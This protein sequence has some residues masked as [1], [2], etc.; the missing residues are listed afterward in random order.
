MRKTLLLPVLAIMFAGA[1]CNVK[2]ECPLGGG[3]RVVEIQIV[4]GGQT[5]T[6]SSTPDKGFPAERRIDELDLLVFSKDDVYQY[7]REAF[8]SDVTGSYRATMLESQDLLTV[9]VFA[10][11]RSFIKAWE[12]LGESERAEDWAGVQRQLADLAPE[13]L[14]VPVANFQ[15]LPMWGKITGK[16]LTTQVNKWGAVN[17][18]R[19]VASVDLYVEKNEKTS[20]LVL[21][22]LHLYYA[23]DC[24]YLAP[25]PDDDPGNTLGYVIETPAGMTTTL[26]TLQASGVELMTIDNGS[27]TVS[28][29]AIVA[30]A[31]LYD[32]DVTAVSATKKHTRVIMAGYYKQPTPDPDPETGADKRTKSYYPIDFVDSDGDFRQIVRNWKYVFNVTAC[33][34]PGYGS[35]EEAKDNFPVDLN[36]D[37]IPWNREDGDIGVEGKYYLS[38]DRK[39]AIVGR[40]SGSTDILKL[41][42]RI[43]D[44]VPGT[45]FTL[46]FKDE[47][48]GTERPATGGIAND[49]FQV[50]LAQDDETGK[51]E[52]TVTALDDYTS[53]HSS[54]V[55][56]VRF[57]NIEFEVRITQLNRDKTD[58]ENGG[59]YPSDL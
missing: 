27:G 9:Y 2:S 41:S 30:Q 48:N 50:A 57:R 26:N 44:Q 25:T 38:I 42:Y 15:P 22:D 49:Y 46:R 47:N 14:V 5:G 55:V 32:N 34:G 37:V 24:G 12:A 19:S 6:R 23:P 43:L 35:L 53:G 10:N 45:K 36:V 4:T 11:C 31:F 28:K 17:M 40:T 3:E 58:W 52:L 1:S 33:N 29:D 59:N 8:K 18:L 54:D 56:V 7:R 20:D 13:R 51:A 21:T 39:H 16:V